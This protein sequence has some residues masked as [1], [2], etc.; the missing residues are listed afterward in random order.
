MLSAGILAIAVVLGLVA[1]RAEN[2]TVQIT[3]ILAAALVLVAFFGAV[4]FVIR[5]LGPYASL[6]GSQLVSVWKLDVAAKNVPVI[7]NLPSIAD[8]N[9]NPTGMIGGP[10]GDAGRQVE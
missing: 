3:L 1:F 9:P 4:V 8:P 6:S 5:M 7:P 10:E 2:A